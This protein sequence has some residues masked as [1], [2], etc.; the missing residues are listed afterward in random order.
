MNRKEKRGIYDSNKSKFKEFTEN[1]L[2]NK[3]TDKDKGRI[4]ER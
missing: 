3:D 4:N 2:Q 1:K